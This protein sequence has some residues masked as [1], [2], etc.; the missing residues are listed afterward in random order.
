[1]K[2]IR[3]SDASE[4]PLSEKRQQLSVARAAGYPDDEDKPESRPKAVRREQTILCSRCSTI[5]VEGL[6]I[7][8]KNKERGQKVMNLGKLGPET[9]L[10]PCPLCRLFYPVRIQND[11]NL[12]DNDYVLYSTNP[13][14][15]NAFNAGTVLAVAR[16]MTKGRQ[17]MSWV[18]HIHRIGKSNGF[19]ASSRTSESV[20]PA[21][22]L[23]ARAIDTRSIDF[24]VIR[25]WLR[26]CIAKHTKQCVQVAPSASGLKNLELIDC[27][28]RRIIQALPS[29]K[30][31]ALSY[32]WGTN[33]FSDN[34]RFVHNKLPTTLP[35]TI[36]DALKV[37]KELGLRHIWIDRYCINQDDDTEK[38]IQIQQM[39]LI[40]Q[41][42]FIAIIAAAGTD[43]SFGLPGVGTSRNLQPTAWIRGTC[44][45][46]ILPDPKQLSRTT[47]WIHRA[48]TYQESFFSTR[49]LVFTVQQVY[50]EC[51]GAIAY[52]TVEN[53]RETTFFHMFNAASNHEHRPWTICSHLSAYSGRQLSVEADAIRAFEGICHT[54]K[55]KKF[56]VRQYL[57]VPIMPAAIG[58]P[59]QGPK[60]ARR[61]RG[62]AFAA[63]LSWKNTAPG[64][65]R[66]RFPTWSWAGW[67]APFIYSGS[68][69][70]HGLKLE[71]E[72]R[73]KV[74]VENDDG[75]LSDMDHYNDASLD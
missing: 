15:P 29:D 2:R 45:V 23:R 8:L 62:E 57:G 63:G 39:D 73:L 46:S 16:G 24:D 52:E 72:S 61:S 13:P 34:D 75:S 30:Y 53:F 31:S 40:Y 48:W 70:S 54:F 37:T 17:G 1:M 71:N 26:L 12:E 10:L 4:M 74:F 3:S 20:L 66:T 64:T 42:A 27:E 59:N 67:T 50:Y 43:P 14:S 11:D 60:P 5:D 44:L 36:E 68:L 21:N 38:Q 49:C 19:I 47:K 22:S 58:G 41:N 6:F 7:D 65:R 56:P 35:Q 18:R 33:G 9:E 25:G 32:V 69:C 28:Q 55:R 51:R